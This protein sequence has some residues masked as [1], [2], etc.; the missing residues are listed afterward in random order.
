MEKMNEN[1]KELW[2]GDLESK[3]YKQGKGYLRTK[4]DGFC[5]FGVL[6]DRYIKETGKGEWV[7]ATRY[8]GPDPDGEFWAFKDGSGKTSD[9]FPTLDVINWAGLKTASP[10]IKLNEKDKKKL[11]KGLTFVKANVLGTIMNNG[12]VTLADMNDN[13]KKF[14]TIAKFIET[15]L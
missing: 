14:S 1:V 3:R 11:Q 2:L 4:N 10:S 7:K 8:G 5:C 12:S 9:S 15:Y 6:C 13:G